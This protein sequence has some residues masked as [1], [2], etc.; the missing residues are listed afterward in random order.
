MAKDAHGDV[1]LLTTHY[2][3]GGQRSGNAEQLLHPDLRLKDVL[4][5]MRAASIQSGIPWRICESNSFS[6]G[7]L[8]CVSDTFIGA[9]W[10]LDFMLLLAE[11][12]C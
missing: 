4:T 12:G 10:T 3:R 11:H 5:R 9:L 2:Y 7:G 8:P 6:G 1:Q